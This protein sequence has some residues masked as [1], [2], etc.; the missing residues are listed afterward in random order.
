[1]A[2][3]TAKDLTVVLQDRPGT[4]AKACEAIAKAGI[5]IEGHCGVP[6][7][8]QGIFH[9]LTMDAGGARRALE[10]AGFE[11]REQRDIVVVDT[12]DRPGVLAGLFR[13]V[14]EAD[15]NV[16]LTY[17]LVAGRV[18][19]GSKDIGRLRDALEA[20]AGAATTRKK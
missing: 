11:V 16:D 7:D 17:S 4:I 3:T 2:A 10:G 5:N 12:E 15:V 20:E 14:A 6:S 1:M 13:K 9:V 8:G 19:I 18:A